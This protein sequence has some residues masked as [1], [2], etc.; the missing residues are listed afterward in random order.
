LI[1][2]VL[3]PSFRFLSSK[4]QLYFPRSSNHEDRKIARRH[5]NQDYAM[6]GRLQPSF[7]L[8]AAQSQIDAHN[9]AHADEYPDAKIIAEAGFRTIVTPLHSD[10][11]RAVRP[12]LVLMQAGVFCLLIIGGVNLVNLL[13]IRARRCQSVIMSY[14][15]AEL[16]RRLPLVGAMLVQVQ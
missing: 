14:F 10:H 2:G 16:G 4:A 12:T 3:P 5:A 7:P 1:V 11:V 15:E 8:A 9:A 6:I 13:L